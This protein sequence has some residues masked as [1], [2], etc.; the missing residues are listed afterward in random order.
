MRGSEPQP[1]SHPGDCHFR[2]ATI[3]DRNGRLDCEAEECPFIPRSERYAGDGVPG[4]SQG[5]CMCSQVEI[6]ISNKGTGVEEPD[7][8][9]SLRHCT[10]LALFFSTFS[11]I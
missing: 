7:F 6:H 3:G 10:T 4:V 11:P 9:N 1:L 8:F 5:F 2:I